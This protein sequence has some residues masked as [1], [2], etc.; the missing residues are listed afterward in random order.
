MMELAAKHEKSEWNKSI[1]IHIFWIL[2][3]DTVFT[4]IF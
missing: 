2:S 4:D 3:G 1:L